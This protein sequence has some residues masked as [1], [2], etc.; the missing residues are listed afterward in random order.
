M[1]KFIW[2]RTMKQIQNNWL[3]SKCGKRDAHPTEYF[4]IRICWNKWLKYDQILDACEWNEPQLNELFVLFGRKSRIRGFGQVIF[5]S[6]SIGR[7]CYR[8]MEKRKEKLLEIKKMKR[9]FIKI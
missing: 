7:F 8:K 3:Q 2:C 6:K 4:D 9:I 5:E 1:F